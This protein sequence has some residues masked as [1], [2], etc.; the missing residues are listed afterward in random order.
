[1]L[2]FMKAKAAARKPAV[3]RRK[4]ARGRPPAHE[5]ARREE[6]LLDVATA[7]FLDKGF[8]G[9]SMIEIARRAGASKQTLY[10][11]YPSKAALF[12]ALI[13]RKAAGLFAAIG[14]L[15]DGRSLR[16]T[17]VHMGA[18]MLDL[19]V[20]D[21]ARGVHR[22]VIAECMEFPELGEIFWERG[23]GRV[24]GMLAEYLRAQQKRGLIECD[25]PEQAVE[26]FLGL[27]VSGASLRAWLGIPPTFTRTAAQRREWAALAVDTFLG[28]MGDTATS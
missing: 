10:A 12:A 5:V 14:P 11:R 3:K 7:V 13:E 2:A 22:V 15:G 4:S 9:A 28:A 23:P 1:M 18:K 16:E 27:L 24:R 19:I 26:I 20:S 8:K 21:E 17:L 25:D 6:H